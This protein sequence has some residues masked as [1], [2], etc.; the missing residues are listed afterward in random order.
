MD[1]VSA[2]VLSAILQLPESIAVKAVYPTKTQLTVQIACVL[3]TDNY[4][5]IFWRGL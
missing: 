4:T 2:E 3:E 1:P 5:Q